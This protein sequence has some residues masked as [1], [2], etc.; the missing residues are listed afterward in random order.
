MDEDGFEID[1]D[2]RGMRKF[3]YE[4]I[5]AYWIKFSGEID[6]ISQNWD[7]FTARVK[8]YGCFC[9]NE[10]SPTLA[11]GKGSARDLI[12]Q[13]CKNLYKCQTCIKMDT[14]Q[15]ELLPNMNGECDL[16]SSYSFNLTMSQGKAQADI[17]C[18]NM[19]NT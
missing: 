10:N 18:L 1:I 7:E 11:A 2:Q 4:F 13:S 5:M 15:K 17:Q 12:D 19:E 9:F 3:R 14:Q 6:K 16:T 8:H